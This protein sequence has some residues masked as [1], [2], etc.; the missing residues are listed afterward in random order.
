V[1]SSPARTIARLTAMAALA[2]TAA[3]G[4]TAALTVDTATAATPLAGLSASAAANGSATVHGMQVTGAF[5]PL[6]ASPS[7][8]SAYFTLHNLNGTADT[9]IKASSSVAS[10]AMPMSEDTNSMQALGPVTIPG[11]GSVVFT[12]GHD[13][14]MLQGLTRKLAVGQS[15]VVRF[16]F[17]HAGLVTVEVPVVP[18][19]RILPANNAVSEKQAAASSKPK[20]GG[21]TKGSPPTTIGKMSGMNMPGM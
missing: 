19:D 16:D 15:V 2:A 3:V 5:L 17:R 20:G 7:V 14:L 9:L 6:P 8:A 10:S 12:P 1:I 13:H 11:H 18:L 21:S 4:A